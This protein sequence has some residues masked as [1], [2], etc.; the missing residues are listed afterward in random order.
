M[1]GWNEDL[2]YILFLY[3]APG[4]L[5][6]ACIPGP[7]RTVTGVLAAVAFVILWYRFMPGG[8][9]AFL[10]ALGLV[11]VGWVGRKVPKT[12]DPEPAKLLVI[13]FLLLLTAVAWS[14]LGP[15]WLE[16]QELRRLP[17]LARVTVEGKA[18]KDPEAFRQALRE[19]QSCGDVSTAMGPPLALV[20][21]VQGQKREYC[22]QYS[23]QGQG[24]ILARTGLDRQLLFSAALLQ[25][26][27]ANGIKVPRW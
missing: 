27:E 1:F 22:L 24:L 8:P 2:V 9:T 19:G 7:A 10:L 13:P 21:E 18:L 5:L 26:V 14:T 20:L 16:R 25:Q 11:T 6:V 17:H 4:M 15:I 12:R 3:W 23:H